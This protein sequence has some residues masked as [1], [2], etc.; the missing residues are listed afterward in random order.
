M[1]VS[2]SI[3]TTLAV[4][5]PKTPSRLATPVVASLPT[6]FSKRFTDINMSVFLFE[7]FRYIDYISYI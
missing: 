6:H 4:D 3:L 1:A 2:T 7:A 5:L